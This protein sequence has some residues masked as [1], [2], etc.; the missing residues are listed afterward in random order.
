MEAPHVDYLSYKL[1]IGIQDKLKLDKVLESTITSIN[2]T[3]VICI[4]KFLNY[5]IL[6]NLANL[7][8]IKINYAS[9]N[10]K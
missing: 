7:E 4:S 8:K 10:R 3:I 6:R 5:D 2:N 1:H 9:L